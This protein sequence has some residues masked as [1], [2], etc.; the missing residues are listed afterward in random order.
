MSKY[1]LIGSEG[2]GSVIVE[3]AMR[4]AQ[5]EF[6]LE[7]IP[8]LEPGPDRDR[9]LELNPLG[10][11]PTL[12]MPDG[13]VM[14]ESAAIILHLAD[15]FPDQR[16][17]PS[18]SDPQR[19]AFLRWLLYINS[20]IYPTTTFA[21]DPDRWKISETKSQPYKDAIDQYRMELWA[22]VEQV[23]DDPYFLGERLS[24]VDFYIAVMRHW[25]PGK[26]AFAKAL[27]KLN[28][29]ADNVSRL[30]QF[31]SILKRNFPDS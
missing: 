11:V 28:T 13:S 3:L 26:K 17:V 23:A 14:T 25:R 15:A 4:E 7:E 9:L 12:I 22:N 1:V 20:E 10:Q 19:P 16:F 21:D 8:Y 31:E 5:A 30:P 6:E 27:P 24:A 2:C 18:S 29:I